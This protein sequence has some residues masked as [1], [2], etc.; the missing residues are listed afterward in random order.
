MPF[1]EPKLTAIIGD[2]THLAGKELDDLLALAALNMMRRAQQQGLK[3]LG[4]EVLQ[5]LLV[6]WRRRIVYNPYQGCRVVADSMDLADLM[7]W[8]EG[9]V[10]E[11][12]Q[13]LLPFLE[14]ADQD[15]YLVGNIDVGLDPLLVDEAQSLGE[16]LDRFWRVSHVRSAMAEI[17]DAMNG[18]VTALKTLAYTGD[19]REDARVE[20]LNRRWSDFQTSRCLTLEDTLEAAIDDMPGFQQEVLEFELIHDLIVGF[21]YDGDCPSA[22]LFNPTAQELV[23]SKLQ[24]LHH[25][26]RAG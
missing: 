11:G 16:R 26:Q 2:G 12:L 23:G 24:A 8:T 10:I 15:A 7:D 21:R 22:G 19:I 25:R 9:R 3:P 20:A 17:D 5:M 4:A 13:E 6:H 14:V 18:V 1:S